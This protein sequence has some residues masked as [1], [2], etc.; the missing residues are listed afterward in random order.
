MTPSMTTITAAPSISRSM[1]RVWSD[2]KYLG[3]QAS[4]SNTVCNDAAVLLRCPKAQAP[5]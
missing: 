2:E 1:T 3:N 5:R 4:E